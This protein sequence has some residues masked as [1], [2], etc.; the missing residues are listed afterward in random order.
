MKKKT[1]IFLL[2]STFL[3]LGH[4][5]VESF[6]IRSKLQSPVGSSS[7]ANQQEK[8]ADAIQEGERRKDPPLFRPKAIAELDRMME[9][10]VE[11]YGKVLD[12]DDKPMAGVVIRC[13]WP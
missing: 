4:F 11:F 8:P 7:K 10:R 1:L 12:Q 5:L 2:A 6:R 3:L 13:S 9:S